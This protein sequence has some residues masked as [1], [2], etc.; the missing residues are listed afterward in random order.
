[1]LSEKS[2]DLLVVHEDERTRS[3][4]EAWMHDE[5]YDGHCLPDG[6][7]AVR[8]LEAYRPR[9]AVLDLTTLGD[10]SLDVLEAIRREPRLRDLSLVVHV[11]VPDSGHSADGFRAQAYLTR[12]IDWPEMRAEAERFLH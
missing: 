11:A 12:G 7:S 10:E 2:A 3:A 8:F 4:A 1:M 5:G 6:R 9:F